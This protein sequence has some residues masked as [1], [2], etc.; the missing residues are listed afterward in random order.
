MKIT[1]NRGIIN[2]TQKHKL[3]DVVE[4]CGDKYMVI[5]LQATEKYHFLDLETFSVEN[6][7]LESGYDS[8]EDMYMGNKHD[9]FLDAELIIND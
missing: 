5:Y 8:L 2:K 7:K 6:D 3:G 9:D 1:D 4:S